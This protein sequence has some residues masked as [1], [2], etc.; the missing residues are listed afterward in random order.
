MKKTTRF[1]S[2][3]LAAVMLVSGGTMTG[4]ADSDITN[5]VGRTDEDV[6]NMRPT[7]DEFKEQSEK[8]TI[9]MHYF[10]PM[11]DIQDRVGGLELYY[12]CKDHYDFYIYNKQADGSYKRIDIYDSRK[13]DKYAPDTDYDGY[14]IYTLKSKK[15]K[16]NYSTWYTF[17]LGAKHKVGTDK[18]TG[19]DVYKIVRTKPF[20]IKTEPAAT[21]ITKKSSSKNSVKVRWNKTKGADGYKVYIS[22]ANEI[23]AFKTVTVKNSS[24][25]SYTFKGLDAGK[26]YKVWVTAY[27]KVTAKY[28]QH[29]WC[30]KYTLFGEGKAVTVKTK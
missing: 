19:K 27:D 8:G 29:T 5:S 3:A 12:W 1:I 10:E 14:H 30:S 9:F 17:K 23:K 20:K 25:T 16:L 18:A 24:T 26:K 22:K 6:I 28:P 7:E 15:L 13:D 2:T 11:V 21:R 4:F